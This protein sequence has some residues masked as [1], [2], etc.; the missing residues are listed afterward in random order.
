[1]VWLRFNVAKEIILAHHGEIWA[2]NRPNIGSKFIFS[3]HY[4]S[5]KEALIKL[6]TVRMKF[7][8]KQMKWKNY[9]RN[10]AM[11]IIL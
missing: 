11:N 4:N 7:F 5:Q 9:C 3:Y 8:V 6:F 10:L 1:M 2:E